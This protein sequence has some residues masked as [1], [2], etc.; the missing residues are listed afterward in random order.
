MNSDLERLLAADEEGRARLEATRAG[1]RRAVDALQAE[2]ASD[3][4]ARRLALERELER[5][6]QAIRDDA[7]AQV[8]ER[9]RQRDEYDR[10]RRTEAEG[11]LPKAVERFVR[12]V[13]DGP[14]KS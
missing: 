1:V 13:R 9:R 10:K 4:A 11:L 2:L 8:A 14:E 7:D 6:L 5:E 3:R 12:I